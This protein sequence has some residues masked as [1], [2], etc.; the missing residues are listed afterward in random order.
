MSKKSKTVIE[1]KK[2][3]T[4]FSKEE[5][6]VRLKDVI[7]EEEYKKVRE[8]GLSEIVAVYR[9]EFEGRE[10][11][12]RVLGSVPI[13]GEFNVMRLYLSDGNSIILISPFD[14]TTTMS[15]YKGEVYTAW[16]YVYGIK[17]N[18][19]LK[20]VDIVPDVRTGKLTGVYLVMMSPAFLD[21]DINVVD[22][23]KKIDALKIAE[24]KLEVMKADAL[25]YKQAA[26]SLER[27]VESV[28]EAH[29]DEAE[30]I[31]EIAE[32]YAAPIIETTLY[33]MKA[34]N[35]LM[36]NA[37]KDYL[38]ENTKWI[39]IAKYIIAAVIAG[40]LIYLLAVILR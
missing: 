22:L 5:L 13:K 6:L 29:M 28:R 14:F 40:G 19:A 27:L 1:P 35:D 3:Y 39:S 37:R 15:F 23:D 17:T 25:K 16:G 24:K 33:S 31:K 26:V 36:E 21:H 20:L 38:S 34:V 8:R 18:M 7:P 2:S 10:K 11:R 4:S 32:T 9:R 12:L 30:R